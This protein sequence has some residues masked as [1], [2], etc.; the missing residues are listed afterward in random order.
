MKPT[1][2]L[3]G[4]FLIVSTMLA[5]CK[6]VSTNVSNPSYDPNP[7]YNKYPVANAG[8]DQILALPLDSTVLTGNLSSDPNGTIVSYQWTRIL[9]PSS[10]AIINPQAVQTRVKS[11]VQGVYQFELKVTGNGGL[12]A[13]DTVQIIVEE[14]AVSANAGPDQTLT[15]PLDSAYLDGTGSLPNGWSTQ[16]GTYIW[17]QISG[18]SQS[19][20]SPAFLDVKSPFAPTTEIAKNLVPGTYLFKLQV[21]DAAGAFSAD[22]VQVNV[23]NDPLDKNT[24]TFHNLVWKVGDVYGLPEMDNFLNTSLRLDLFFSNRKV[25]PVEVYLNFDTAPAW[26]WVPYWHGGL[27]YDGFGEFLWIVNYP[28]DPSLAERKSSIKIKLL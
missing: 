26:I 22:T 24:V 21:T 7:S 15:L 4:I 19:S 1:L 11:L 8:A 16:V 9:G 18:P 27:Y 13:K 23:I 2:K 28:I 10:F 12:S 25:K 3:F 14:P 20:I 6:K 5:F 17:K